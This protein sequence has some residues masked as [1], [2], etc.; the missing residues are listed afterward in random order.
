ML[1]VIGCQDKIDAII[2]H[3]PPSKAYFRKKVVVWKIHQNV[4]FLNLSPK[5]IFLQNLFFF[6]SGNYFF[7]IFQFHKTRNCWFE[8]LDFKFWIS[9]FQKNI[10]FQKNKFRLHFCKV[11]ILVYFPDHDGFNFLIWKRANL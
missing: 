4:H 10:F 8:I 1:I 7:Q 9:D 5:I 6:E 3:F 2:L 11:Y